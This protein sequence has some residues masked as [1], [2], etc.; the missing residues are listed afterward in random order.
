M[1]TDMK[2]SLGRN[3]KREPGSRQPEYKGSAVIE[4]REYWISGWV[5]ENERGKYFSLNFQ[6]KEQPKTETRPAAS[7]ELKQKYA[8]NANGQRTDHR[9][10]VERDEIPF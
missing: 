9:R 4:G 1:A 5:N 7:P 10:G 2:G 3:E 6:A 8:P